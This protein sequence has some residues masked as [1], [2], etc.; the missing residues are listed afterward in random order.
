MEKTRNQV[1]EMN[2]ARYAAHI[3]TALLPY[4]REAMFFVVASFVNAMGSAFLWPLATLYVYHELGRSAGDAGFVLMLQSLAGIAGQLVGGALFH[5]LG[6]KRLIVGSLLC[7][8]ALQFSLLFVSHWL[9][10]AAVM[11]SLG[12]LNAVSMPAI[13][14]YIGFRWPKQRR[15]LFNI[16]YVGNNVGMAVGTSLAGFLAAFSFSITFMVDGLSTLA[17]AIFFFLFMSR[18]SNEVIQAGQTGERENTEHQPWTLL[19]QYKVYLFLALGSASIWFATSVWG[20][21][22]APYITDRGMS[23]AAYSFLWTVNG[24]VI[25]AGQ[26]VT[27]LLKRKIAKT[28]TAQLIASAACYTIGFAFILAFHRDYHMLVIGMI[29]TTFGEM[30]KAPTVPAFITENTGNAAPFYLGV[31][32]GVGNV[33][34]LLGPMLQ[35]SMY[36]TGG[37]EP[38]VTLATTMCIAAFGFFSIHAFFHRTASLKNQEAES[39]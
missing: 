27:S 12:F 8:A 39:L 13:Q 7:C 29:I 21:G 11:A 4:P 28:L 38:V 16:V 33:G 31:V 32:G 15:Q 14:A 34:R 17:F 26:P 36:D 5:R 20:T 9:V 10:Y 2:L 6:A 35:G 24:I 3:R 23:M 19:L 18:S 1:N 30:L 25:F 37:V 22:V